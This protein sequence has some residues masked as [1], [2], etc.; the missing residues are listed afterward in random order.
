MQEGTQLVESKVHRTEL[1]SMC[2]A[3]IHFIAAV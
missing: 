3:L 2:A 1:F